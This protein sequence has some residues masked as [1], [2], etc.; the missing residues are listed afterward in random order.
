MQDEEQPLLL[1]SLSAKMVRR[2]KIC[3]GVSVCFAVGFLTLAIVLPFFLTW[4]ISQQAAKQ[5]PMAKDN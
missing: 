1:Q 3:I 5:I 4:V 2:R